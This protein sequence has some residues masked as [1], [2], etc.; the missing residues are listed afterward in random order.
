M[1]PLNVLHLVIIAVLIICMVL[2]V[3]WGNWLQNNKTGRKGSQ[4]YVPRFTAKFDPF[5]PLWTPERKRYVA[6][7]HEHWQH[8]FDNMV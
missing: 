5:L 8:K 4:Y 2:G 1:E 6:S 3:W 7:E